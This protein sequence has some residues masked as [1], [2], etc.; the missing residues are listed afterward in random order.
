MPAVGV[1]NAP[2]SVKDPNKGDPDPTPHGHIAPSGGSNNYGLGAATS[3]VSSVASGASHATRPKPDKPQRL[4]PS[5]TTGQTVKSTSNIKSIFS[6]PKKAARTSLA[7][8]Y[9]TAASQKIA[10]ESYAFDKDGDIKTVEVEQPKLK[11]GKTQAEFS[12]SMREVDHNLRTKFK[13]KLP[14]SKYRRVKQAARGRLAQEFYA[15]GK[16]GKV[17]TETVEKPKLRISPEKYNKK[18]ER[19]EKRRQAIKQ[20]THGYPK[21]PI[22]NPTEITPWVD[23]DMKWRSLVTNKI[24]RKNNLPTIQQTARKVRRQ[25]RSAPDVIDDDALGIPRKFAK[26]QT[27]SKQTILDNLDLDALG[28][29]ERLTVEAALTAKDINDFKPT[30][31]ALQYDETH[32]TFGDVMGVI[33]L[34]FNDPNA[35]RDRIIL[36][37][38]IDKVDEVIA[39][40]PIGK[41]NRRALGSLFDVASD[42]TSKLNKYNILAGGFPGTDSSASED[43]MR[44]VST[45]L[46]DKDF[47]P[48]HWT[49]EGLT[50]PVAAAELGTAAFLNKIG[51][52][53][54]KNLPSFGDTL[55][56]GWNQ[57]HAVTG[58][59][60][61]AHALPFTS[62]VPQLG[63]VAD[64]LLDPLMYV[65]AGGIITKSAVKSAAM[66]ERIAAK[67]STLLENATTRALWDEARFTGNFDRVEA[68][69]N[70]IATRHNIRMSSLTPS[71]LKINRAVRLAVSKNKGPLAEKYGM[72]T[73]ETSEVI[74]QARR[75]SKHAPTTTRFGRGLDHEQQVR[76]PGTHTVGERTA[77]ENVARQMSR[78][79]NMR[80]R[81]IPGVEFRFMTPAGRRVGGIKFPGSDKWRVPAPIVRSN[82]IGTNRQSQIKSSREYELLK[83]ASKQVDDEFRRITDEIEQAKVAGEGDDVLRPL[84]A[85]RDKLIK[86]QAEFKAEIKNTLA[87]SRFGS[88]RMDEFINLKN[89]RR[90]Y[91]EQRQRLGTVARNMEQQVQKH[92]KNAGMHKL[93]QRERTRVW[94]Y[95]EDLQ[96]HGAPTEF[97]EGT[98]F[99]PL[100][101]KEQHAVDTLRPLYDEIG[102]NDVQAGILGTLT[103]DYTFR[104]PTRSN[105]YVGGETEDTHKLLD[106]LTMGT[107]INANPA[108]AHSR[109]EVEAASLMD[110]N[111]LKGLFD[112][113]ADGKLSRAELD[114]MAESWFHSGRSRVAL[115]ELMRASQRGILPWDSTRIGNLTEQQLTSLKHQGLER[116][117]DP[118]TESWH[119]NPIDLENPP[120]LQ[121]FNHDLTLNE[122]LADITKLDDGTV[123][124]IDPHIWEGTSGDV[125]ERK[126]AGAMQSEQRLTDLIDRLPNGEARD[127]LILQREQV[128]EEI[129][130]SGLRGDDIPFH[131]TTPREVNDA[132]AQVAKAD[133]DFGEAKIRVAQLTKDRENA[134]SLLKQLENE[135]DDVATKIAPAP[136][137]KDWLTRID[138]EI[139]KSKA[140]FVE[141]LR[142]RDVAKAV[143]AEIDRLEGVYSDIRAKWAALPRGAKPA[144][145][146]VKRTKKLKNITKDSRYRKAVA[147]KTR[148]RKAYVSPQE[149][150]RQWKKVTKGHHRLGDYTVVK[151]GPVWTLAYKDGSILHEG[152]TLKSVKPDAERRALDDLQQA[153]RDFQTVKNDLNNEYHVDVTEGTSGSVPQD[154]RLGSRY[155]NLKGVA[156]DALTPLADQIDELNELLKVAEQ[157]GKDPW[158]Y[159][160]IERLNA[161]YDM[162]LGAQF[163]KRPHL[164]FPPDPA[165]L[166]YEA[167]K[168]RRTALRG[169]VTK[170]KNREKAAKK[171]LAGYKGQLGYRNS[172]L[173]RAEEAYAKA[174]PRNARLTA[175]QQ[176]A[177]KWQGRWKIGTINETQEFF[178]GRG[179]DE[180]PLPKQR[181]ETANPRAS[182]G[183]RQSSLPDRRKP[184]L[185]FD[186]DPGR[187]IA[188]RTRLSATNTVNSALWKAIDAM[189][190]KNFDQISGKYAFD[191]WGG[192]IPLNNLKPIHNKDGQIV[193][194]AEIGAAEFP[195]FH[196]ADDLYIPE[197]Y[198]PIGYNMS[199]AE[200]MVPDLWLDPRTGR[201]YKRLD[202]AHMSGNPVAQS[203]IKEVGPGRFWPV[204][205]LEDLVALEV[206]QSRGETP[207]ASSIFD[208]GLTENTRQ[209]VMSHIRFGV[210]QYFPAY[211]FRNLW[212][213]ILKS[214]QADSGVLF[215]PLMAMR[216]GALAWKRTGKIK[217]KLPGIEAEL[218]PEEALFVLDQ[219]GM[220][221]SQHL[222]EFAHLSNPSEKRP[223]W[224]YTSPLN[225]GPKGKLGRGVIEA[226]AR[227]EDS[228]RFITFAQRMKRNGGDVADATWYSIKHHFDYADLS[229][230]ERKVIRNAFLFY[231]WYR[232]NI[233]LQMMELAT[234]PGFFAAVATLYSDTA[235]G[236]GPLNMPFNKIPVVGKYLP[237]T[238][239]GVPNAGLIPDYLMDNLGAITV[240]YN[241]SPAAFSFGAPWVDLQMVSNLLVDPKAV[242]REGTSMLNPAVGL[243]VSLV[244]NT[245]VITGAQLYKR[246]AAP[247]PVAW[248]SGLFGHDLPE[249]KYGNP[250][251]PREL[252]AILNV[253]P[254]FGRA[255]KYFTPSSAVTDTG[256]MGSRGG[257]GWWL[258]NA[259]LGINS[260]IGP[261]ESSPDHVKEGWNKL[262]N[263]LAGELRGH[264]EAYY[265]MPT[266]YRDIEHVKE[267]NREF[268]RQAKGK[269]IPNRVLFTNPNSP[270]VRGKEKN[271]QIRQRK[272]GPKHPV[273]SRIKEREAEGKPTRNDKRKAKNEP[274]FQYD[275]EGGY[276]FGSRTGGTKGEKNL[277]QTGDYDFRKERPAKPEEKSVPKPPEPKLRAPSETQEEY[278]RRIDR[279]QQAKIAY[280]RKDWSLLPRSYGGPAT[281]QH[282]FKPENLDQ[283]NGTVKTR[284]MG[285]P[286]AYLG[287]PQNRGRTA[288]TRSHTVSRTENP[289]SIPL[290]AVDIPPNISQ[291]DK[292]KLGQVAAAFYNLWKVTNKPQQTS[293]EKAGIPTDL[294][295]LAKDYTKAVAA[296]NPTGGVPDF[297]P[298]KW[299]KPVADAATKYDVPVDFFASLIKAESNYD[300]EVIY[301][302]R[303]SSAGAQGIAQIMPETAAGWGVDPFNPKAA[304]DAAAKNLRN[305]YESTGSWD[306][307]AAAY[308]AGPGQWQTAMTDFPET[309]AYID[310]INSYMKSATPTAGTTKKAVPIPKALKY[311]G[312]KAF[313]KEGLQ[314]LKQGGKIVNMKDAPK[315]LK[316]QTAELLDEGDHIHFASEDPIS[317]MLVVKH[318]QDIGLL[319]PDRGENPAYDVIDDPAHLDANESYHNWTEA[320][321]NTPY[322]KRLMK[323]TGAS[324]GKMGQAIDMAGDLALQAEM[325]AWIEQHQTTEV[326]PY[327]GAIKIKGTDY[328]ILPPA[329]PTTAPTSSGT[330]GLPAAPTYNTGAPV[331]GAGGASQN[332]TLTLRRGVRQRI[333]PIR[334]RF[335]TRLEDFPGMAATEY[336][337]LTD[338]TETVFD[339]PDYGFQG[340]L[341]TPA[342]QQEAE[343][344]IDSQDREKPTYFG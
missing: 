42:T 306:G 281:V 175:E 257:A 253:V 88:V 123:V 80:R 172:V 344:L 242:L 108:F 342:A 157:V 49:L 291:A 280:E 72:L 283:G 11:P 32:N 288:P 209:R 307:A 204:D 212:S 94:L 284:R 73:D 84:Y 303:D 318:A 107:S 149:I 265:N 95:Q 2:Q 151:D 17:K 28:P 170:A 133:E 174:L 337:G 188:V 272:Y 126:V 304:L 261:N 160:N 98:R 67:D 18:V 246:Q 241:G 81:N 51:A 190:G 334:S 134:E 220:T 16:D 27:I 83:D 338:P 234:R 231:T 166:T 47:S 208:Q 320:I 295:T 22:K 39:N 140:M 24:L 86:K 102:A 1:H 219:F 182:R 93:N 223:A 74:S 153:E 13:P 322:A 201:E 75:Q 19:M 185:G 215:H 150:G 109:T 142:A 177:L 256:A 285:H 25:Q 300:D 131:P 178:K 244:Y 46:H 293:I 156:D 99:G 34:A 308:N 330:A 60:I 68:H 119:M 130:A 135:M 314:L 121:L 105:A 324:G 217:I 87:T 270:I 163:G 77:A 266:E 26:G 282:P 289:A 200:T 255:S 312:R 273:K 210:T 76:L 136:G 332:S 227:R 202:D 238:T 187:A 290:I 125:L 268:R 192:T 340:P 198:I 336:Y 127:D 118:E 191:E 226:G 311:A 167:L 233:P 186:A 193:G 326:D 230:Y 171:A 55:I 41:S 106:D 143:R 117:W 269:G 110:P 277:N 91:H 66:Y 82:I 64:I 4:S 225:P 181:S 250:T 323:Q 258:T 21:N 248:L 112:I 267:Y 278:E 199:D 137:V 319:Q 286:S 71:E 90:L 327:A 116:R 57:K 7:K 154:Y 316:L 195:V 20:G 147:R 148:L 228:I 97:G 79:Y 232:K 6:N 92:M 113:A 343:N 104:I 254:F 183:V 101:A 264:D 5:K 52:T 299:Q 35:E 169:A 40:D 302:N 44:G 321:P 305:Y 176:E 218:L 301:G 56:H 196:K 180:I 145:K 37:D 341:V 335:S 213:D 129:A 276:D 85:Q 297:V 61:L 23:E 260:Y 159:Y 216:Y 235:R 197:G 146:T 239:G 298:E 138:D 62:S 63:F 59:K 205:T 294:K 132:R 96:A 274:I 120:E 70:D 124:N 165:M 50:R 164:T 292:N 271:Q 252:E 309:V 329:P 31:E 30:Y 317:M 141:A 144:R 122:D 53:D 36:G 328:G 229:A 115:E 155:V 313:G 48:L 14:E 173:A 206:R 161:L 158:A 249:D 275:S 203:I 45:V 162:R 184:G 152:P 189:E 263:A 331:G 100:S 243:A 207:G 214:L 221:S 310:R 245:D 43:L 262:L 240:N 69:L 65:G 78:S 3:G 9:E 296:A 89:K 38:V 211:H 315:G 29:N 114:E 222:A 237:D 259:G 54:I 194:Y 247:E 128:R 287:E 251:M 58:A 139:K 333:Q 15:F 179:L 339:R 12:R 10:A 8:E 33:G 325:K 224:F 236:E 168:K 111:K 279:Y 103:K